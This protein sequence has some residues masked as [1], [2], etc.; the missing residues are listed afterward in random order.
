[1]KK[2]FFLLTVVSSVYTHA[3]LTGNG[4]SGSTMTNYTSGTA[5]DPIY[6]WCGNTLGAEQGSLTA[7]P[8]N[9]TGP[10]TFNWFYHDQTTFS[11]QPFMTQTGATSTIGSLASD[12]YRCEIKDASNATTDCLVAWVWNMN[13]EV[14]PSAALSN[15]NNASLTSGVNTTGS[16]TYYNTPPPESLINASTQIQVCFNATHTWVSDLAFYLV[17]PASCGSPTILL[18]LNPGQLGQNNICNMG[19]NV[20]NLCFTTSGGGNLNVC[21]PAPSTLSGTYSSYGPANTPI[22]WTGLI[23]CNAAGGNFSVQVYDCIAGDMGALTNATITFSNLTSFCGSPTTISYSSGA[24]NA[25]INDG[26]CSPQSAST[27]SVPVPPILSTPLTINAT[28]TLLW[29]G[30]GAIANPTAANTTSSGLPEGVS[31]FTLTA[32]TSYGNAICDPVS[33]STSVNVVYP[34]VDAG[35]DRTVCVGQPT[36]L[37]GSGAQSYTW[38]NGVTNGVAFNPTVTATYTVI[39]TAANGCTDTDSLVITMTTIDVSAGPD[40]TICLGQPLTLSGSGA[41]TYVWTNP[42]ENNVSFYPTLGTHTYVVQGMMPNGCQDKD[43]ITVTV[44]QAPV[45]VLGSNS[46][47][48]G[49]PVLTVE[50]TNSSSDANT[51]DFD[52]GNNFQLHTTDLSATPSANYQFPGTYTVVLTAGNG[53]CQD[54]AQLQVIVL[55]HLPLTIGMPNIFTPNGDGNNDVFYLQLENAVSVEVTIVNRWGNQVANFSGLNGFWD[56]KINGSFAESG[57]YFYT[58][59]ATGLDGTTQTGQGNVQLMRN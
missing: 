31:N 12:G 53:I 1:M 36:T 27:F 57:V 55:P 20:T 15:C 37:S 49:N 44:I 56:G 14:V 22:N 24:I 42:V 2:L 34:T 3:Q 48:T 51:Y 13:T 59:T 35:P 58:Y 30:A 29:T 33:A 4:H 23:G 10:F 40:Q 28:T 21:N 19:D 50:F 41:N 39:G 38:N 6:I 32:T 46:P 26:T 43:T 52:F 17:G 9:G 8:T 47:L 18:S 54:T 45:A 25:P 16:F 7:T 11:W 5:N